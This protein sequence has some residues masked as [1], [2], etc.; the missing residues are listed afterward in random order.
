[1]WN[2]NSQATPFTLI[3][4]NSTAIIDTQKVT[5]QLNMYSWVIDG[6]ENLYEQ[7][8]FYRTGLMTSES[9]ISSLPVLVQ[10]VS[11]INFNGDPDTLFV[12]YQGNGFTISIAYLL[13]GG[14]ANSYRSDIAETITIVNTNTT[15]SQTFHFFQ[16]TDF[17]LNGTPNDDTIYRDSLSRFTQSDPV[18][19]SAEV[20][21]TSS[22]SHYEASLYPT[23]RNKLTDALPTTLGDIAGPLYGDVSFAWQWDFTVNAGDSFQISKD[24]NI[25]PIPEPGTLILLGGGLLSLAA[26]GKVKFGRKKKK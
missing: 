3:D 19:S 2:A 21:T 11:D 17:D 8:F 26:Y 4:D 1:M 16:Y 13:Q 15:G 14:S 9:T 12:K 5:E 25:A 6:I 18:L 10:G 23:L 24:K 20:I 7:A 22:P